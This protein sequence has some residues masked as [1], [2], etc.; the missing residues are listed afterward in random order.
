MHN[1]PKSEVCGADGEA[2]RAVFEHALD[3][4][5]IADGE[6]RCTDA[7][8]AAGALLGLTKDELIGRTAADFLAAGSD[9]RDMW[10]EVLERRS[11]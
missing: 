7:N 2:F 4:M 6:G 10:A 5:L 3:A 1:R 9:F 11:V 8:A